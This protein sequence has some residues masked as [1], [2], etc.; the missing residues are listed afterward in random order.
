MKKA[1][2]AICFWLVSLTWGIVITACGVI[3]AFALLLTLHK[4]KLYH[5]YIWFEVGE[6]WGGLSLGGVIVTSKN[7]SAHTLQH[8]AGHGIQNMMFGVFHVV[9]SLCSFVRCMYY[10]Y[11]IKKGTAYKLKP[12]DSIWFEGMAT[13]LGEKF[14]PVINHQ[15]EDKED[16]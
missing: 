7:P 1:F 16:D 13:R 14:F 4:P 12:Y 6:N 3:V 10:N 9:I 11:H 5:H 15:T 2:G 8:E